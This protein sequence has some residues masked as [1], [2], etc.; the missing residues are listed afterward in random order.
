MTFPKRRP[1]AVS[2]S[3]ITTQK[4]TITTVAYTSPSTG[5]DRHCFPRISPSDR[6]MMTREQAAKKWKCSPGTIDK[7][8]K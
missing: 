2:G 5:N 3:F 1:E 8:A 6:K 4:A 7:Y